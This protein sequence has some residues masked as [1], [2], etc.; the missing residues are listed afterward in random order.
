M[1]LLYAIRKSGIDIEK[2][3]N[4]NVRKDDQSDI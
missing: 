2:I 1:R 3:Y 4:E